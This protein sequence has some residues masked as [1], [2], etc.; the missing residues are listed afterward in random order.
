MRPTLA[1]CKRVSE[2][3]YN[4]VS[5]ALETTPSGIELTTDPLDPRAAV[6]QAELLREFSANDL[7]IRF[8]F[9]LGSHEITS[10]PSDAADALERM[11]RLVVLMSAANETW[12]TVH[13]PLASDARG[14]ELFALTRT[15]LRELVEFATEYRVNVCLENLCWGATSEPDLFLDLIEST[16]ALVTFD[17]GH[18]V[19]SDVSRSGFSA[20]KFAR[21]LGSRI[22]CA[23]VYGHEDGRHYPPEN[24]DTI[25][26]ALDILCSLGCP[27]WTIELTDHNDVR[28]TRELLADFLDARECTGL[29]L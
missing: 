15:R 7:D 14:T 20:E 3:D 18:A 17:V 6:E 5:L 21:E 24:L 4:S 19:S 9:P 10:E 12:L 13:A 27:W 11:K 1:I 25:G 16:G 2:T 29:T 23:H 26:P 8:H 22:R 28:F